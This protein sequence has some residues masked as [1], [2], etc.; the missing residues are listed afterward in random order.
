[1]QGI[2]RSQQGIGFIEKS[3]QLRASLFVQIFTQS[4]A[5]ITGYSSHVAHR[6]RGY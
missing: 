3:I 4:F 1:M 2:A 6:I 5:D